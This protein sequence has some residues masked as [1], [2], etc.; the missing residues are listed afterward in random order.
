MLHTLVDLADSCVA[1]MEYHLS[2]PLSLRV[3]AQNLIL[4]TLSSESHISVAVLAPSALHALATSADQE[5]VSGPACT[6]WLAK[7]DRLLDAQ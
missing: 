6:L 3:S 5:E 7:G 2:C 4:P 1:E